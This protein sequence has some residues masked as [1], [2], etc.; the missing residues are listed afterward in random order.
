[1]LIIKHLGNL[2]LTDTHLQCQLCF[3]E[4]YLNAKSFLCTGWFCFNLKSFASV[5]TWVFIKLAKV[6]T[7]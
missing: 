2:S 7:K 6:V 4:Q 5:H 1:M 3:I